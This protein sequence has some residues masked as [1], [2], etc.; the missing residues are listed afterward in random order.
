MEGPRR[1]P[2][3]R[4]QLRPGRSRSARR[5]ILEAARAHFF[6]HGFRNVTMDDLAAELAVS[7]KTL[8]AH[9]PSKEALLAAVL[10]DK[11]ERIRA[12]LEEVGRGPSHDFPSDL[13]ALLLGLRKELDELQ[14]PF[15]RDMRKA[16]EVFKH[17]EQR[18]ARLIRNHFGRL[19][20]QGQRDGHVRTDL[21]VK[22]MTETLLASVQ[23]IMNPPKLAEL[24]MAPRTAFAGL[25]NLLLQGAVIR[26]KVRG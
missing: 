8:Y 22:L 10:R 9:F 13:Q 3:A 19:F 16:P 12:T 6:K 11:Y 1:K 14:P 15:L 25:V 23:A 20:H 21:P 18:R 26:K 4:P 2:I 7:K 24:G 17:L 5:R